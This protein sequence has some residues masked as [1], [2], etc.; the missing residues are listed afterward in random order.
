MNVLF[1]ILGA[2]IQPDL[3][4]NSDAIYNR[5]LQYRIQ[6][7]VRAFI[8]TSSAD[9]DYAD[10]TIEPRSLEITATILFTEPGEFERFSNYVNAWNEITGPFGL[11]PDSLWLWPFDPDPLSPSFS[12]SPQPEGEQSRHL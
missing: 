3:Y 6:S 4:W 10:V 9:V 7:L 11:G 8:T 1:Q 12:T 5:Y 2:R